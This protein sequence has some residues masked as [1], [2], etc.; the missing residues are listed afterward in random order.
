[1]QVG[2]SPEH[3]GF[4]TLVRGWNSSWRPRRINRGIPN[5][6]RQYP[7][8]AESHLQHLTVLLIWRKGVLSFKAQQRTVPQRGQWFPVV[9]RLSSLW[10]WGLDSMQVCQSSLWSSKGQDFTPMWS[11]AAVF[12]EGSMVYKSSCHTYCSLLTFRYIS[13][14]VV[15][16]AWTKDQSGIT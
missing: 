15:C 2:F 4:Q 9:P 6:A 7:Q 1:M 11:V 14:R 10:R 13:I 12:R 16:P 8:A 3:R 5:T